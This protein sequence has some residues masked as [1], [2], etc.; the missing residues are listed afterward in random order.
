[1]YSVLIVDDHEVLRYDLRRMKVWG[2]STG[3]LIMGEADNGLEALKKLKEMPVD[4]V[5]TDIR[6]PVMDGLELLKAIAF[7]KL[8]TCV[9]LLSDYT[10]Y[11]YAREGLLH[12]AF[13]YLG[14]PVDQHS[15][16]ELLRRVKSFLDSKKAE[17]D[18][19]NQLKGMAEGAFSPTQDIERITSLIKQAHGQSLEA[20]GQMLDTVGSALNYDVNKARIIIKNAV[21]TII[22][23]ILEEHQWL[24]LYVDPSRFKQISLAEVKDWEDLRTSVIRFFTETY[25]LLGKFIIWKTETG[26]IRTACLEVLAHIEEDVSVRS[27]SEKLYISKAYLSELFKQSTGISL[28]EYITMVKIERA[29]YLLLS[30]TLKNYEVADRLGF[31]DHEYFSKIFKKVSGLSPNEF[32]KEKP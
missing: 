20:C 23:R 15:I 8:G 25:A 11:S 16:S 3:F 13:D 29:K 12:G 26:P 17:Q 18:R 27:L 19:L 5:I 6:M 28:L 7:E 1:M 9:V 24:S 22:S 4:L 32:R 2:E 14:K 31:K 30:G 21:E 10:E